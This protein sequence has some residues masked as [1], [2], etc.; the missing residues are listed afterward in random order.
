MVTTWLP[1]ETTNS[2]D[3]TFLIVGEFL[4]LSK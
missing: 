3:R 1:F 2:D 4:C